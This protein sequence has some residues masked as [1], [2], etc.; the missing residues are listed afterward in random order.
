MRPFVSRSFSW[1]STL[2][3]VAA[4][5][6]GLTAPAAAPGP[7]AS[8]NAARNACAVAVADLGTLGGASSRAH[9]VN[10]FGQ[11]VGESATAAGETHAFFW[12]RGRMI[13]LGTLGGTS[14]VAL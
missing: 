13:D 8:R 11:V 9:D 2:A 3:L 1:C 6:D 5:G 10:V 14:S 4:C 12:S 7:L